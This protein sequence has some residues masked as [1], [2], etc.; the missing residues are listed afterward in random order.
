[1]RFLTRL[2]P[3]NNNWVNDW[4]KDQTS[5]F[6]TRMGQYI[7]NKDGPLQLRHIGIYL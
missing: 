2:N 3:K 6:G 5:A 1:M 4:D 7:Q